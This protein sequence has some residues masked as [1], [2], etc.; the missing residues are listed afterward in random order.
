[1]AALY[2][3]IDDWYVEHGRAQ[4]ATEQDQ[5]RHSRYQELGLRTQNKLRSLLHLPAY[6]QLWE[7]LLLAVEFGHTGIGHLEPGQGT[8]DGLDSDNSLRVGQG[9]V[10][11]SRKPGV[12]STP[13]E[14]IREPKDRPGDIPLTTTGPHGGRRRLVKG[15]SQGLQLAHAE[16]PGDSR[17][18]N[19]DFVDGT[20]TFNTLHPIWVRLDET[21]GRHTAKHAKWIMH[22]QEWLTLQVLHLLLHYPDH[23]EFDQRRDIVDDQIRHYVELFIIG[24]P[25][26]S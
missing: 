14:R 17:L 2:I 18:W 26:R 4:H 3:F 16:L 9:G 7:G 23:S 13:T 10:G 22:L 21:N 11:I 20:L 8:P 15:D 5:S 25:T 1:L 24:D 19:F 12:P 6:A